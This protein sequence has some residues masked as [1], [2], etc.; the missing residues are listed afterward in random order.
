MDTVDSLPDMLVE[1]TEENMQLQGLKVEN[2]QLQVENKA[3]R[4]QLE[5]MKKKLQLPPNLIDFMVR[6]RIYSSFFSLFFIRS[7]CFDLLLIEWI[8]LKLSDSE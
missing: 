1:L 7:F 2:L 4:R 5:E 8:L 3:I 6:F